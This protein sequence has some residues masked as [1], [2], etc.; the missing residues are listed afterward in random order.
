MFVQPFPRVHYTEADL[1]KTLQQLGLTPSGSLVLN[2]PSQAAP[3]AAAAQTGTSPG[4]VGAGGVQSDGVEAIVDGWRE[5][6]GAGAQPEQAV[7]EAMDDTPP[8]NPVQPPGQHGHVLGG[9]GQAGHVLGGQ[10]QAGHVLGG[11]GQAGHVLGGQ[12]QAGHVLGGQ[13]QAGHVLGGQGQTGHA[14]GGQGQAGHVL[15]GHQGFGLGGLQGHALGGPQGHGIGGH[16]VQALGGPRFAHPLAGAP[17]A[18]GPGGQPQH[19][20]GGGHAL[21]QASAEAIDVADGAEGT[22]MQQFERRSVVVT[23]SCT[24]TYMYI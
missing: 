22:G 7:E 18:G 14:L 10:G 3:A 13:G 21:V 4:N 16:H 19:V 12:G 17:P 9:Q 23:C 6:S 24:C 8:P 20:W 1:P 15:G 11:Q 5:T 2:R